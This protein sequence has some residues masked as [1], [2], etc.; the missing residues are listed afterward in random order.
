[1][2][3]VKLFWDPTGVELD[4]LGTNT[5]ERITD[6]DTPYVS[7]AIR[8]LSI[9]TAE[10][11]Y[12]GN[13][14]PAKHDAKLAQLADW[15]HGGKAPID[16]GLA[17]WLEP[18]LATGSAGTLQKQQGD[19]AKAEFQRLLDEKLTRPSGGKR[20]V[21]L[22]T[23]DQPFD[24][25]GRL[26]AYMSPY[27]S[28]EELATLPPAERA[29]F[30]ML[31]VASGWAATFPIYPSLPKYTDL[32]LLQQAAEDAL[33]NKKGAWADPAT[34]TG[35][36]FRMCYKLWEVTNKLV[37]GQKLS[38]RERYGWVERYCVDMTNREVYSP[39]DY[40]KVPAYNRV[41]IWPDDV[42]EA[43]G[44]LNLEPAG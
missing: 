21:F 32:V 13:E 9:D 3:K 2:A 8:M 37:K 22:R 35:Y 7:M 15:I 24:Q 36:E 42:A 14:S 44:R 27:Y 12:P 30:N 26:L 10:V 20:S 41:F 11:H 38:S 31:M 39:Q 5:F 25:Y 43:V 33:T 28:S 40:Y 34:L 4:A 16:P 23:A 1:M 17:A 18:K 29:T 6:G 19:A